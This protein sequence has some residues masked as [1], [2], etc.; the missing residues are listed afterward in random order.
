MLAAGVIKC[1]FC[2][3]FIKDYFVL[4]QSEKKTEMQ[5]GHILPFGAKNGKNYGITEG[6]EC[7]LRI[8]EIIL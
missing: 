8:Y 7:V 4:S 6:M 5:R 3:A 2:P 1:T